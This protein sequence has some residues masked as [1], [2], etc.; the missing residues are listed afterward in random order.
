MAR[1]IP[2]AVALLLLSLAWQNRGYHASS[3]CYRMISPF[4][5]FDIRIELIRRNWQTMDMDSPLLKR[6]LVLQPWV[7]FCEGLAA[8]RAGS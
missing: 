7:E 2:W 4:L 8:D 1:W 3:A 5:P 6:E